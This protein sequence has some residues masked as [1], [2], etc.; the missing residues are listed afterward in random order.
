MSLSIAA[1]PE[2][3]Q[4]NKNISQSPGHWWNQWSPLNGPGGRSSFWAAGTLRKTPRVSLAYWEGTGKWGIRFRCKGMKGY[5]KK[6]EKTP[7]VKGTRFAKN[8]W[9]FR[10]LLFE[11]ASQMLAHRCLSM[12]H[13]PKFCQVKTPRYWKIQSLQE[14]FMEKM[15]LLSNTL[16]VL[17]AF[18][19]NSMSIAFLKLGQA[20]D[21][22]VKP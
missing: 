8:L 17:A 11:A 19:S 12:S 9:F 6:Y 15:K 4:L 7:L 13:L 2:P 18:L 20:S 1:T 22:A 14:C 10:S 21:T 5:L 3:H 16:N